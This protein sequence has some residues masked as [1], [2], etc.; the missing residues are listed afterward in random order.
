[1]NAEEA[2]A[3]YESAGPEEQKLVRDLVR[4][5]TRREGELVLEIL[6]YFP[7]AH[8]VKNAPRLPDPADRG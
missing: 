2:L 8:V 4:K 5:G 7:G 6:H 1:M 3:A